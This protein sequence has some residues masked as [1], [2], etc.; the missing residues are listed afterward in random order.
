MKMT[1]IEKITNYETELHIKTVSHFINII[2]K[3]LLAKAEAHDA[4][5]LTE[6]ELSIF[7][8]Y[9]P[10]LAGSTY[11]SAE[12][13]GFLKEMEVALEHHYANNKHHPQHF[14]NGI[15]DM[16][17]VDIVEMFCDWKAATLRHDNGNLLKSIDIN[18]KRFNI[19]AQ[20]T[21][22]LKNTAELFE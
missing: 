13:L 20:L 17:L 12:Y 15:D 3:L 6:P 11:G 10:K 8:E 22:I 18:S 16:T 9:T 19:D 1:E 4:S 14:L 2:V 21:K 5:K 7:V